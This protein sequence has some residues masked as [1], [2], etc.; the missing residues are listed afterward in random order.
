MSF[1]GWWSAREKGRDA[2]RRT[3]GTVLYPLEVSGTG[4]HHPLPESQWKFAHLGVAYQSA[5]VL[6]GIG[7]GNGTAQYLRQLSRMTRN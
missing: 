7:G 5:T 1:F 4:I 3:G 6:D 2:I